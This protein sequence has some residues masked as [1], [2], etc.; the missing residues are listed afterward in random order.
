MVTARRTGV[1]IL[2]KVVVIVVIS[3]SEKGMRS[4]SVT[5]SLSA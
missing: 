2:E 1:A 3:E 5:A 4:E